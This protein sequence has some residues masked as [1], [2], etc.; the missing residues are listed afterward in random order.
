M[1]NNFK[2]NED[3]QQ[4][5]KAPSGQNGHQPGNKP[6]H[7]GPAG[8][9]QPG[10]QQKSPQQPSREG[11]QDGQNRPQDGQNRPDSNRDKQR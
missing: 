6:Q 8:S 1:S 10:G 2:K 9:G 3:Q 4:G 11:N 5:N 7:T